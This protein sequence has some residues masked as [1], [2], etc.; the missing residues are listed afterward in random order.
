M[1]AIPRID[2]PRLV[3]LVAVLALLAGLLFWGYLLLAPI[4]GV[5]Q[6]EVG[7]AP[8][9]SSEEPAQRWFAAPSSEIEVSLAGLI[10][11]GPAAIAILSVNGAP[12]QAYREGEALGRAAK[13][14]RIEADA[15]LIEQNG[16][17]RR[18]VMP[19]LPEPPPLAT[20]K[21]G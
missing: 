2:L 14:R 17:V 6:A 8:P 1:P 19:R 10:G 16:E 20:L 4:P 18:V 9:V 21:R 13:V 12:L 11:G 5:V 15:V 7:A 3:Q